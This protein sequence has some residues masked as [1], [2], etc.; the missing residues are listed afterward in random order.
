MATWFLGRPHSKVLGEKSKGHR[1]RDR[2]MENAVTP[3][4]QGRACW[5]HLLSKQDV[6]A[7]S[8]HFR[9]RKHAQIQYVKGKTVHSA[10]RILNTFRR[11]PDEL[12]GLHARSTCTGTAV[13]GVA[14]SRLSKNLITYLLYQMPGN[15]YLQGC[16]RTLTT[17]RR[18]KVCDTS[19]VIVRQA[20]LTPCPSLAMLSRTSMI[21]P[22]RQL[23][24]VS[25]ITGQRNSY[26]NF[27]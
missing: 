3:Q 14:H 9:T 20:R 23:L 17:R 26:N 1:L 5:S 24:V 25:S 11:R 12:L 15:A 6:D 27:F 13:C 10:A 16:N 8:E 19:R 21:S 22:W 4:L 18:I 2:P 7:N